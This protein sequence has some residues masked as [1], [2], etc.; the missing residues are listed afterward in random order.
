MPLRGEQTPCV[1]YARYRTL[2]LLRWQVKKSA[3][4]GASASQM[5][6]NLGASNTGL[7]CKWSA[8]PCAGSP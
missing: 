1:A 6:S 5:L 4:G 2:A 7:M 3:P 8:L